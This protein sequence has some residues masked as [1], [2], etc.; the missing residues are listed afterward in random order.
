MR[1]RPPRVLLPGPAGATRAIPPMPRREQTPHVQLEGTRTALPEQIYPMELASLW[2]VQTPPPQ[3]ILV[4]LDMSGRA[5]HD[6]HRAGLR[7]FALFEEGQNGGATGNQHRNRR[8]IFWWR[9]VC[10]PRRPA[11]KPD[12]L[13]KRQKFPIIANHSR[14]MPRAMVGISEFTCIGDR[15]DRSPA[16]SGHYYSGGPRSQRLACEPTR[17]YPGRALSPPAL[18]RMRRPLVRMRQGGETY[19]LLMRRQDGFTLSLRGLQLRCPDPGLVTPNT[20]A[21]CLCGGC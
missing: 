7:S 12:L 2:Q 18:L 6:T 19:T 13:T 14:D 17:G 10:E 4:S 16:T 1:C 15:D 9:R 3:A 20:T 8:C 11:G 21:C 5:Q